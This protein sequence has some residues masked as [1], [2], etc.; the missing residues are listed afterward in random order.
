MEMKQ[1]VRDV[2]IS[3][4]HGVITPQKEREK[5]SMIQYLSQYLKKTHKRKV[6]AAF[7]KQPLNFPRFSL[8]RNFP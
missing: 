3:K 4:S 7:I 8:R 1:T 6:Q 5:A 2:S